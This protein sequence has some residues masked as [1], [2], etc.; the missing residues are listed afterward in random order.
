MDQRGIGV[1]PLPLL[2]ADHRGGRRSIPSLQV[3]RFAHRAL[4]PAGCR[5]GTGW[6]DDEIMSDTTGRLTDS[7]GALNPDSYCMIF[8]M[9]KKEGSATIVMEVPYYFVIKPTQ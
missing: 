4:V 6:K 2:L 9:K 3:R 8:S 5:G 1:S 7:F